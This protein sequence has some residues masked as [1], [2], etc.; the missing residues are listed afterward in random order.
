MNHPTKHAMTPPPRRR[1]RERGATLIIT[2][3]MLVLITLLGLSSI[4]R[5]TVDERSA[6][7]NRDRNKAFQAAEAAV[8][9]CLNQVKAAAF[10]GTVLTPSAATTSPL[11]EVASNWTNA[12]STVVTVD[13]TGL[14]TQPRCMVERFGAGTENYR[15]TGRAVGGSALTEVV[16]QATYSEET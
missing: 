6:G 15:V 13:A 7:A 4:R 3:V 12:N 5:S 14:S 9:T 16:V 2:L 1:R 10:T 8:R 11:W